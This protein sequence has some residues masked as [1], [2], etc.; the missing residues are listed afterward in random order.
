MYY[1][2]LI[3]ALFCLVYYCCCAAYA[4]VGSSFITIWLIGAIFFAGIFGFRLAMV[5]GILSVPVWA[6]RIFTVCMAAVFCSYI[7]IELLVLVNLHT[8]PYARCDY[9]IILGCRVKGTEVSKSLKS[10]LDT[11]LEYIQGNEKVQIIVSGGQGS[12]EDISEALAM[13][14]YLVER[15]VDENRIFME[16]K[17][18]DTAQ[19]IR[20]SAEYI[21]DS[22]AKIAVVSNDFHLFR[23]KRLIWA[24][25]FQNV[26]GIAA[27]TDRMLFFNYMLRE[28]FGVLKDLFTR[29]MFR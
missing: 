5:K 10:R 28:Y 18:V 19:N 17:S 13:K 8:K 24:Q 15:G 27:P 21:K 14:N 22:E 20:F 3:P 9:V 16:D 6:G 12:G 1:L 2:W 26:C 29:N 7:L 4:G 23:A 11:A 25:G